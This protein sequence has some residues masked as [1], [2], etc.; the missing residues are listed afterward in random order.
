MSIF[1]I[2]DEILRHLTIHLYYCVCDFSHHFAQITAYV[3][4][5]ETVVVLR[6]LFVVVWCP[7]CFCIAFVISKLIYHCI[8]FC[9]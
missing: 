8:Y 6:Y 7:L 2:S 5:S 4:V 1:V 3:V 9:C